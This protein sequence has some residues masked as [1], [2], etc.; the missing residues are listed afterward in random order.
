MTV[1]LSTL[2]GL[3]EEGGGGG[4]DGDEE[5]E[6]RVLRD[7]IRGG[8]SE[9]RS[10]EKEEC[11]TGKIWDHDMNTVLKKDITVRNFSVKL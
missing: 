5:V 6:G 7:R 11:R 10:S 4:G 2:R 9:R 3:K 1:H 8:E